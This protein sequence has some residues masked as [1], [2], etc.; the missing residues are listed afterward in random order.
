MPSWIGWPEVLIVLLIAL[1]VFG[2]KK[3]PDLARALGRS[4]T[5]FKTGLRESADEVK[6]AMKEDVSAPEAKAETSTTE[7]AAKPDTPDKS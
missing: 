4:I 6:A 2:P 5:G 7:P 3:L 1:V